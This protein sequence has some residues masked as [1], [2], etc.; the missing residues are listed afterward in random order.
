MEED[1]DLLCAVCKKSLPPSD[2]LNVSIFQY[3]TTSKTSIACKLQNL[4]S[5]LTFP[6]ISDTICVTCYNLVCNIEECESNLWSA[7]NEFY[8]KIDLYNPNE[9]LGD[10]L[11]DSPKK[12]KLLSPEIPENLQESEYK[13]IKVCSVHFISNKGDQCFLNGS[14]WQL[15]DFL[16][17]LVIYQKKKLKHSGLQFANFS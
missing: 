5:P 11:Y 7:T 9:V 14:N 8:L 4:T 17:F 3:L 10:P 12:R 16:N 6:L 2:N 13:I 1:C 15:T